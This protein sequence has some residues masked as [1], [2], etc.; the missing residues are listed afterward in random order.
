MSESPRP[1]S[2][3]GH[4]RARLIKQRYGDDF[5]SRLGKKGS[6]TIRAKYGPDYYSRLG[7]KG[8]RATARKKRQQQEREAICAEHNT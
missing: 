1:C 3:A 6:Q 8:G 4:D 2:S 7:L 5:Y